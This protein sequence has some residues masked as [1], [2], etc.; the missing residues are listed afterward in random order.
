MVGSK[1]FIHDRVVLL[2]ISINTFL[3]VFSSLTLLLR[4]GGKPDAGLIVEYR[5]NL[6]LSAF[7][8]GDASTFIG[9]AVFLMLILAFHIVLSRRIYY[10]R[11]H[12]AH[13]V[14]ALGT[15]LIILA[16]I[17]SNSLLGL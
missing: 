13:T 5:S 15:L 17:V 4:L 16:A 3:A 7:K 8:P 12:F 1:K 2:L 11:R 9:F 6:G 10:V 14:L